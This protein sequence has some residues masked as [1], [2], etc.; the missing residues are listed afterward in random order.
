MAEK[1]LAYRRVIRDSQTNQLRV[2]FFDATTNQEI[3]DLTGYEIV[4]GGT[5]APIVN[6][7]P[8]TNPDTPNTGSSST[9]Y[10]AAEPFNWQ[11]FQ[12]RPG[13]SKGSGNIFDDIQKT[14]GDVKGGLDKGKKSFMD[15]V[16]GVTGNENLFPDDPLIRRDENGKPL[17]V[18][19]LDGPNLQNIPADPNSPGAQELDKAMSDGNGARE[20][21]V[22][23]PDPSTIET[24]KLPLEQ[25]FYDRLTA[26]SKGLKEAGYG[27]VTFQLTSMGQPKAGSPFTD[28]DGNTYD[29]RMGGRGHDIDYKTGKG[30]TGDFRVLVD[31]KPISP[32]SWEGTTAIIEL[33]AAVGMEGI[34]IGNNIIHAGKVADGDAKV[35]WGYGPEGGKSKYA[36]PEWKTAYANGVNNRELGQ[37]LLNTVMAGR[38]NAIAV[39]AKTTFPGKVKDDMFVTSPAVQ[40][41]ETLRQSMGL[42]ALTSAI[43]AVGGGINSAQKA[44]TGGINSALTTASDAIKTQIPPEAYKKLDIIGKTPFEIA[45]DENWKT[46]DTFLGAKI[47]SAGDQIISQMQQKGVNMSTVGGAV[48]DAMKS[49]ASAY[50][51]ALETTNNFGKSAIGAIGDFAKGF[52]KPAQPYVDQNAVTQANIFTDRA[53]TGEVSRSIAPEYS[54]ENNEA[55][56]HAVISTILG[57]ARG[58]DPAGWQAVAEVIRNRSLDPLNRWPKDPIEIVM[59]GNGTQFNPNTNGLYN[60]DKNSPLYQ[61][62]GEVVDLV[63]TGAIPDITNG[64]DHFYNPKIAN[65]SWAPALLAQGYSGMNIGNH[66]FMSPSSKPKDVTPELASGGSVSKG[67]ISPVTP[68]TDAQKTLGLSS[69]QPAASSLGPDRSIGFMRSTADKNPV[70]PASGY[71]SDVVSSTRLS[72]PDTISTVFKNTVDPASGYNSDVVS[73]T[74]LSR[75]DTSKIDIGS[76]PA[77][78][79]VGTYRDSKVQS[80]SSSTYNAAEVTVSPAASKGAS[81]VGSGFLSSPVSVKPTV[82]KTSEPSPIVKAATTVKSTTSAAT[83]TKS[84]S[85]ASK[86]TGFMSSAA[87]SSTTK[88]NK[89]ML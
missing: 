43:S 55:R 80:G 42:P 51:N 71:N 25:T 19:P 31:G 86:G 26:V 87:T 3:T 12:N 35:V 10:D 58:E 53:A 47:P 85:A 8:T 38:E 59:Q 84:S 5:N 70:N 62:V 23:V 82:T 74:R 48:A 79:S 49:G 45:M 83:T 15:W 69:I 88:M 60:A 36:K 81:S 73:R 16:I 61:R 34:G 63:F 29:E 33:L 54:L 24:R 67:F 20:G 37:Q 18:S 13:A 68:Q 32:A 30:N 6:T 17:N 9:N 89:G 27:V 44:I 75:P 22:M 4:D 52:M 11:E 76:T 2:A 41:A 46:G 1:K 64:A 78:P 56:R 57:E 28:K 65:P 72:R 66:F 7:P 21:A 39:D 77:G 40:K 50:G 14:I